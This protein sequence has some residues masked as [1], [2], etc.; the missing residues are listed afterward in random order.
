MHIELLLDDNSI[1]M[2]SLGWYKHM[3]VRSGDGE[4]KE[5]FW[6][7]HLMRLAGFIGWMER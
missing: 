6:H 2:I 1:K 3:C 7:F 4:R 5:G